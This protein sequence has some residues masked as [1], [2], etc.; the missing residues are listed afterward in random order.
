MKTSLFNI[1]V[2]FILICLL[3]SCTSRQE[4]NKARE[5]KQELLMEAHIETRRATLIKN[6]EEKCRR[7]FYSKAIAIVDSILLLDA[8]KRLDTIP[9]PLKITRPERPETMEFI[10]SS[11]LKPLFDSLSFS[12]PNQQET[13]DSIEDLH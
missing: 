12:N 9:K 3:Y 6:N 10:D 13:K 2:G 8:R 4:R 11:E 7:E 1:A 5:A